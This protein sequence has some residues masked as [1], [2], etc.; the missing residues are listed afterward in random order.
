[1]AEIVVVVCLCEILILKMIPITAHRLHSHVVP[2]TFL[3]VDRD[4]PVAAVCDYS[5]T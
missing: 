1:M 3:S 2:V 4:D 5:I